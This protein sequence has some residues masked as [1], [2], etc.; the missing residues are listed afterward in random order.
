[1]SKSSYRTILR[2]SSIIG[3]SSVTSIIAGLLKMKVAAVLL[4]P[5]GVGLIGLYVSLMQT[6]SLLAS[7]GLGSVGAREISQ[8]NA[9]G[10]GEAVSRKKRV[11]FLGA[12]VLAFLGTLFFWILSDWIT[13]AVFADDMRSRNVAWLALGVGFLVAAA[14]QTA[15]LTGLRRIGDLARVNIGSAVTGAA[16]GAFSL[17]YWGEAGIL[18]LVLATPVAAFV[19]GHVYVSRLKIHHDDARLDL[20]STVAEWSSM[21]R[22]G[23]AFMLSGL[24]LTM[25]HL[26]IR[27]M[28]QRELGVDALG[29]FQAAWAIGMQY[30]GFVL[31]AMGT[32]YFPRLTAEI[33][34]P[35]QAVRL[36]N[37]QTEVALLLCA[38][39]LLFMLG[40]APWIIHLLYSAEFTPA[41]DVLRLQILGDVLKVMSWPA[42]FILLA[43]GAGKTFFLIQLFSV[44]VFVVTTLLG[45][46]IIGLPAAGIAFLAMYI[47]LLPL[48]FWFG[49]KQIGLRW[50]RANKILAFMFFGMALMV[51]GA[52]FYSELFSACVAAVSALGFG[53]LAVLRLSEMVD[54]GGRMGKL[55]K[56][57]KR[58]RGWAA[59]IL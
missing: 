48:N 35:E 38:P 23:V 3:G 21:V 36:V 4:G 55:V 29:H 34:Q 11:L 1:M 7:L 2:S 6:A 17:W 12:T 27:T 53:V 22:L 20:R 59:R 45:L 8:A 56:L 51:F 13:G 18:P 52:S 50:T 30:L 10:Q 43:V 54:A 24:V 9:E 41:V 49:K 58:L 19:L 57:G 26:L 14:S 47:V 28:V 32:D 31:G 37:E 16:L 40:F 39:L 46:P 5:A 15:L 42:G 33:K 44:S 25:A